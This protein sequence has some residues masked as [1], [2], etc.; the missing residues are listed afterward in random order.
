MKIDESELKMIVDIM[1]SMKVGTNIKIYGGLYFNIINGDCWKKVNI[2]SDVI[3]I[4]ICDGKMLIEDCDDVIETLVNIDKS[5]YNTTL[6]DF[7]WCNCIE[8]NRVTFDGYPD[9]KGEFLTKLLQEYMDFTNCNCIDLYA[10]INYKNYNLMYLK[11]GSLL[12]EYIDIETDP[13][14]PFMMLFET[15]ICDFLKRTPQ[16]KIYGVSLNYEVNRKEDYLMQLAR[17]GK[18]TRF[19][20]R[21]VNGSKS[22]G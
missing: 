9:D 13:N 8:F 14:A 5:L 21:L 4:N 3:T 15:S 10:S 19:K 17:I 1:L 2:E 7:L 18:K 6:E 16:L 11:S 22:R 12:R 20:F